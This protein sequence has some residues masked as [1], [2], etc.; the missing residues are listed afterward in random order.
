M[1][2]CTLGLGDV[3]KKQSVVKFSRNHQSQVTIQVNTSVFEEEAEDREGHSISLASLQHLLDSSC[4]WF[5]SLSRK[6]LCVCTDK[7]WHSPQFTYPG[8]MILCICYSH[9]H[10]LQHIHTAQHL[11]HI[12]HSYKTQTHTVLNAKCRA[13]SSDTYTHMHVC[14][15]THTH[16]TVD[17]D[18]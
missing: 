7:C 1:W 17:T 6:E 9:T 4:P 15:L 13:C 16:H 8:R 14:A 2:N 12:T 18:S 10:N 3:L 11:R 5:D